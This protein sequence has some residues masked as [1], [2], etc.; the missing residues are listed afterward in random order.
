MRHSDYKGD[1]HQSAPWDQPELSAVW[2]DAEQGGV[3]TWPCYWVTAGS[4]APRGGPVR[5]FYS[6]FTG[7]N[8]ALGQQLLQSLGLEFRES[9]FSEGLVLIYP[10]LS[11]HRTLLRAV[12]R[13]TKG[14][15]TTWRR[16]PNIH[17]PH[18]PSFWMILRGSPAREGGEAHIVSPLA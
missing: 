17:V 11:S 1:A 15:W 9:D 7:S 3:A 10:P 12:T 5:L 13:E 6:R 16:V 4:T 14:G 8:P 2:P 18:L